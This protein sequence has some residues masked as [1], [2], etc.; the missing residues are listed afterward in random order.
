VTPATDPVPDDINLLRAA[1]AAEQLARREA[2]ARAAGAEAMV[3][4]LKLLIAKLKHDRFGASSERGRKLLDQLE[5]QLEEC[6]AAVAEDAAAL[7]PNKEGVPVRGN[8]RGKPVRGPLPAHL[9]RERVVIP[10]PTA[11]PCCHGKLAKLGEDIT[12]TL[13]VIPRQWKVI[14]TVREKFTCRACEAITQP[15]APFHPIARGRAGPELLAMILEAKFGQHLPLN[16]QS[17]SYAREGIELDVSTLADWVGACT[18][19]LVPLVTLIE[20]HVLAA[21]RVHGDDTTVPVL[22]K[23]KTTTGRLWTY[24]RDD[25]PFGGPAPPAAMF[26]YSPDRRGEHPTTHLAGYAAMLFTQEDQAATRT[27]QN[28]E[29]SMC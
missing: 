1:L 28:A 22:A 8:V 21:G 25:K 7:D 27:F 24:V 9:P 29:F 3:A 14:Q 19:T 2:E 4:H 16:R 6:E 20:A 12:E 23:G 5:L 15:P 10:G 17:E 11:C 18:A 13:E 26:Y